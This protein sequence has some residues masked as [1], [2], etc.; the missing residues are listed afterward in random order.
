MVDNLKPRDAKDVEAAVQWALAEGKALELVGHGSKRAIGRPA[1]TDLTL[2]LSALAGVTLYEPEELVL[3]AKAGTPLAEIEALVAAQG[4]QLAFEPMDYAPILGGI[5]GRGTI[6]GALAANLSGPRRIKAGAARDHFLGL[7]AVSGR[8]ETFKSGGRVVKN[9][10]GYDL[11]KL[12]AGSWGTLAA[13]TE[14]TIK[15]L[16]GPET[17]ETVLIRGLDPARAVAAMT[18]AMGSPCDVSGAAHLPAGVAARVP[19]GEIA[20]AG[21]AVTALRLEGFSPSVAHRKHMLAAL[22]TPFGDLATV[23]APVSRT[24]WQAVRDVTPFAGRQGDERPLWR[25]STAPSRGAELGAMIARQGEAEIIYD[26]AGG[27][28]WVALVASDDAGAALVRRAV[29][30]AGGHATLVRAP[31][32]L[33]AA[34]DVFAPQDAAVA[35]LTKRVKESFDPRGVLNPGR[36]WAGV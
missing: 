17:E 6:G 3:S 35:A 30:A 21:G 5:A 31:A 15:V 9:V 29:A 22:M 20:G 36:M 28:V 7:A 24:L 23:E 1:Q 12:I 4:Q 13:M 10:T 11:C 34:A 33:R 2:D 14:V 27:L 8:G 16:P 26:W 18:S 19:A 25:I 32:P